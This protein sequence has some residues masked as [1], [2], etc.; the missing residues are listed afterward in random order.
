MAIKASD[1]YDSFDIEWADDAYQWNTDYWWRLKIMEGGVLLFE[2]TPPT[3]PPSSWMAPPHALARVKTPAS[4]PW[5][6]RRTAGATTPMS[7]SRTMKIFSD[8]YRMK[9]MDGGMLLFQE[10]TEDGGFGGFVIVA[11]HAW[12]FVKGP[13]DFTK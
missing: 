4:T 12:K 6:S 3:V 2:G 8:E 9:I 1:W 7:G 5:Q 11:P 13:F 10:K